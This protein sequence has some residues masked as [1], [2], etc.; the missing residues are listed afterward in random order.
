MVYAY[1]GACYLGI[2]QYREPSWA[3]REQRIAPKAPDLFSQ[4]QLV[5]ATDTPEAEPAPVQQQQPA[6]Q[7]APRRGRF[8]GRGDP[9]SRL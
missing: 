5:D 1:A 7:S 2:Q 3:R 9:W 8:G 6:R 4:P